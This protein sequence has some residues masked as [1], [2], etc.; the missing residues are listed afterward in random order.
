MREMKDGGS[1]KFLKQIRQMK[2]ISIVVKGVVQGVYFRQSTRDKAVELGIKGTVKN[3]ADG[4]VYIQ[5]TGTENAL[6][7]LV[8][9]CHDGPRAAKVEEVVVEESEI[10]AHQSFTILKS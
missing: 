2:S 8:R 4:S 9:W 6:D 10:T 5:A 1:E 7:T 3:M